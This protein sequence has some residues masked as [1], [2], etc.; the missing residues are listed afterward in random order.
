MHL[1]RFLTLC[2]LYYSSLFL[3][4]RINFLKEHKVL[5]IKPIWLHLIL[6]NVMLSKTPTCDGVCGI[7]C[8]LILL[9]HLCTLI[10]PTFW[11]SYQYVTMLADA[12]A[13]FFLLVVTDFIVTVAVKNHEDAIMADLFL[14]M[15]FHYGH[16]IRW[17]MMLLLWQIR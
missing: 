8:F 2:N 14:S 6:E 15:W 16:F 9:P 1:C 7:I 3:Y 4:N 17:L 10:V 13:N 5:L 11:Y 12:I